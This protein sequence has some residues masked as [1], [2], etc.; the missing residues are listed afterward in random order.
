MRWTQCVS[1]RI[2]PGRRSATP[3]VHVPNVSHFLRYR[4][5][6]NR[7]HQDY[8]LL[9]PGRNIENIP[10]HVLRRIRKEIENG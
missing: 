7:Q 3:A 10:A 8:T 6:T 9:E 5:K 4:A 2:H 1:T